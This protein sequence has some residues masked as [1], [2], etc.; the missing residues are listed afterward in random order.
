VRDGLDRLLAEQRAYYDA[1][2]PEY[3]RG[4]LLVD[5]GEELRAALDAFAPAS[6]VLELACGTGVWTAPLLRHAD[7]ITAVDASPRMLAF[8]RASGQRR[9]PRAVPAGRPLRL[10]PGAPLEG[11]SSSTIR[12]RLEDGTPFRAVKVPHEPAQL[13]RRLSAL[14]WRITVR[15]TSG[16]CFWGEGT[17]C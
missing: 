15:R 14:G 10:A 2:A 13:E 7:T 12:R 9:G 1:R 17:R 8:A 11:E 6:D 16:P 5:G 3:D 4:A